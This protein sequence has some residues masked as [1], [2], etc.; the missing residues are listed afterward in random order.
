[1]LSFRPA[2]ENDADLFFAW[3]NDREARNNSYN[4]EPIAYVDHVA[5]FNR[6]INSGNCR[7]YV[8]HDED[9]KPVGQV[10]IEKTGNPGQ[11]LISVSVDKDHR[12][13]GYSTEMLRLAS[14]DFLADDA[15]CTIVAYVFTS[16]EP[17]FRSF[18][19][20][21]YRLVEEKNVKGIPSYILHKN[22]N[23]AE[24]H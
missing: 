18:K 15:S 20:A 22:S 6:K 17:S 1:M 16:N 23:Y 14:D 3:A 10:R 8:F 7:F 2:T 4:Q 5:W 24:G 21:G 13:K 19:S 11:A 12:G 9:G